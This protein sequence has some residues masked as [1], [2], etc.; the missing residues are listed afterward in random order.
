MEPE[1]VDHEPPA[2]PKEARDVVA[3]LLTGAVRTSSI[4]SLPEWAVRCSHVGYEFDG[5]DGSFSI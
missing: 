5:A 3:V 1:L 4:M 2:A